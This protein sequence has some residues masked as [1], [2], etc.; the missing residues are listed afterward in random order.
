MA[1]GE[2]PSWNMIA[3]DFYCDSV[4]LF[5]IIITFFTPYFEKDGK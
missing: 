5:D 3:F 4:F 1:S 2:V